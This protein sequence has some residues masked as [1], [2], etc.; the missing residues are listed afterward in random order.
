MLSHG[1]KTMDEL[2]EVEEKERQEK[3][4]NKCIGCEAATT[5]PAKLSNPFALDP[6]LV[7]D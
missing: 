2:N 7:L 3:E 4:N 1:L 5:A 6:S